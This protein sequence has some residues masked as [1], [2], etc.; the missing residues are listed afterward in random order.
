LF[1]LNIFKRNFYFLGQCCY[2]LVSLI[3][4][5][6]PKLFEISTVGIVISTT[7]GSLGFCYIMLTG[8]FSKI[9]LFVAKH[10][11]LFLKLLCHLAHLSLMIR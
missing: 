2:P 7:A 4:S 9:F 5:L 11:I 10:I 1:L 3:A 8:L 6:Y